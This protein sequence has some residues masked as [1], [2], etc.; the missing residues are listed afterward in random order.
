MRG[1]GGFSLVELLGVLFIIAV[2][3]VVIQPVLSHLGGDNMQRVHAEVQGVMERGRQQALSHRTYI[4]VGVAEVE[5]SDG[6][7]RVILQC[8]ESTTGDLRNNT[9]D[10]LNEESLW[11]SVGRPVVL[12]GVRVDDTLKN[13]MPQGG[14][15]SVLSNGYPKFSRIVGGQSLEFSRSL[16][17]DPLGQV[18]TTPGALSRTVAIGLANPRQPNNPVLLVLS[19]LSGSVRVFRQEAL[20]P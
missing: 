18:S 17:F 9:T 11:R 14:D 8:L 3:S 10:G 1:A 7:S 16:Q 15:A 19:G 2:M 4:R 13:R 20:T 5:T 6:T 12:K